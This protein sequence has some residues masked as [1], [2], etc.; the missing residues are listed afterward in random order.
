MP[1]EFP[2]ELTD[3]GIVIIFN[4]EQYAKALLLIDVTERGISNAFKEVQF[5]KVF[6]SIDINEEFG[7]KL[8]LINLVQ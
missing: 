8:M 3:F 1:K 4:E 5:W 6:D 2:L 7:A